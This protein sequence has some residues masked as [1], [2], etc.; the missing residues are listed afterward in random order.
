MLKK[1]KKFIDLI[2]DFKKIS[3]YINSRWS[4][5]YKLIVLVPTIGFEWDTQCRPMAENGKIIF[6]G[7]R[8]F[9]IIFDWLSFCAA[10]CFEFG[11]TV[12]NPKEFEQASQ[13]ELDLLAEKFTSK[14]IK[15][16]Y[17]ERN[18]N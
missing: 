7:A 17:N 11:W 1:I 18:N 4:N 2:K 15:K 9:T 6:D 12:K 16:I 13:T 14:E 5:N 10:I 8:E 3:F